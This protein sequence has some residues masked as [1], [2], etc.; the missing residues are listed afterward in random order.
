MN[1]FKLLKNSFLFYFRTQHLPVILGT[2]LSTGILVGAL[3]VG[4][5]VQ[6]SLK[7][8]TLDRLGITKYALSS[9][10]R[11][12]RA[13][14][15]NEIA[16]DLMVQ[17]A[18]IL[19]LQGIA[20]AG[21]GQSRLNN[22][23]ILG[24]DQHF[25]DLAPENVPFNGLED[26]QVVINSRLAQKLGLKV[27]DELLL[28][29][30]TVDFFPLDAP[31]A[32]DIHKS[33]AL[34]VKIKTIIQDKHFGRFSLKT[35]QV[36]P[37]NVF[38]SASFLSNAMDIKNRANILLVADNA[39]RSLM[40]NTL[41]HALQTKFALADAGLKLTQ[42]PDVNSFELS[43]E[44][45]FLE[46][47]IVTAVGKVGLEYNGILTYFVNQLKVGNKTTPYSFV[48][49]PGQPVVPENLPQDHIIINQWLADDLSAQKGDT[50]AIEYYVPGPAR[51][52]LEKTALLTIAG[53]VPIKG[54]TADKTLM[55]GFPGLAD[56][57]NCRDWDPG[58]PI[59]L[60]KIRQKDEDYWDT[61]QGT[62]KAYISLLTAQN[63][64]ENRFGKLTAIRFPVQ[65]GNA[66]TIRSAV[67]NNLTLASSI[68]NNL[69]PASVGLIFRPVLEEGLLA[70]REA[71]DFGQLFIGLSFFIIVS[72]LILTGLLFVLGVEKRASETGLLLALGYKTGQVK[73]LYLGEIFII[74]VAGS[75]L[76]IVFGILYN[77]IVL[78]GLGSLWRG[79]VG[80]SSLTL[81]IVPSTL[82][83]GFAIGTF[84][85]FLVIGIVVQRQSL[86]SIVDL[87]QAQSRFSFTFSGK[88]YIISAVT[89]AI[90]LVSVFF[91]LLT[92]DPGRGHQASAVFFAAGSLLLIAGM[93]LAYLSLIHFARKSDIKSLQLTQ[94]GVRNSARNRK[95][96]LAIIG[97]L[98]CGIF[99][100]IGVGANRQGSVLHADKRE[101]G[102]GGFAFWGETVS[103]LL[104]DLNSDKGRQVF[105]LDVEQFRSID[106]VQ[107]RR[108]TG[109]DASCLN[110]NRV[111]QPTI[112]GLDPA[113]LDRRK[114]FTFTKT[115]DNID[116]KH[117]WLELNKTYAE[118][119]LPAI[120]DETVIIWGLGKSVGDT[121]FYKNENGN[122]LKL[123]LIAGLA[124]SI[125]QGNI[126]ISEDHFIDQYPS[127]GGYHA[128]LADVPKENQKVLDDHLSFMMRNFGLVMNP[129]YVRL[130][131]FNKVENTYLSIFLSLGGLGLILGSLG[132]GIVV[133]RNILERR[134][135]MALLS[136]VGFSRKSI[137][138][139][140]LSE[141]IFLLVAGLVTG[142]LSALFAV[143]PVF[144]TPGIAVPWLSIILAV[145]FLFLFGFLWIYLATKSAL[146]TDLIPALR[147]E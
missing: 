86:K 100:V 67:L 136:A 131:E 79:A 115:I 54:Q 126:L 125:F 11:Y 76:G 104:H 22:V 25:W 40:I 98:A 103:P 5:S 73:K 72:A 58:I 147:N 64:W 3:I 45:I 143:L 137:L 139:L 20:V 138:K 71:V 46:P 36:P 68:L 133:F 88:K 2:I 1:F 18:A 77:Q 121:L 74:A 117:I 101:S 35:N 14:L 92:S 106:F 132:L 63:L 13:E 38:L 31:F 75:L 66:D 62:P 28:R 52:L 59:D 42:L 127:I 23:H 32:R 144:F 55:P 107:M 135:E 43:S 124:N 29:V 7:K 102:T 109:D 141:H 123:I 60:D 145:L 78:F 114:A 34:R 112:L 105:E 12:F 30:N 10:D 17:T 91:I 120:A 130:A 61:F 128:F 69:T 65:G 81:H 48:S 15:A 83:A 49:A 84:I 26:D 119:V 16:S 50:V 56:A 116:K 53:I 122:T 87:Q 82:L 140:L 21:G 99:L 47:S 4:D 33:V 134:G 8:M 85:I 27:N 80:T 142:T 93:C 37:Y 41:E 44:R 146:R 111:Q 19:D 70:T 110:L 94:L 6:F 96:S 57:E 24:V 95:R 90:C 39:D 108:K 118:N 51:Q 113:E 97:L 9:G 129:A 89:T